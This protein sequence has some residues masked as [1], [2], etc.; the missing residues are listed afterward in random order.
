M[1]KEKLSCNSKELENIGFND[2][3]FLCTSK[4]C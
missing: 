3:S 1:T 4:R 2:L